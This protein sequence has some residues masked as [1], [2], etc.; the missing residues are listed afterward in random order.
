MGH[1]RRSG[2]RLGWACLAVVCTLLAP[3]SAGAAQRWTTADSYVVSGACAAA[4]PCRIDYAVE[5]AAAGD[6]VIVAPGT[7]D[8]ADS[9]EP[10][11]PLDLHGIAGQPR[12]RLIGHGMTALLSF[13]SGG[14]LRHIA[15]EATGSPGARAKP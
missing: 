10:T 13:K 15:L 7:Y 12:P 9:L 11:V 5:S 6:E 14:S 4:S 8:L 1:M 3:A 2:S